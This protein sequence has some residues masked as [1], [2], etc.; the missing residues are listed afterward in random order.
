MALFSCHYLILV[1]CCALFLVQLVIIWIDYSEG[2]TAIGTTFKDDSFKLL[3]CFTFCPLPAYK[4]TTISDLALES[5]LQSY[6][7]STYGRSDIFSPE[8]LQGVT[9]KYER[10]ILEYF[11]SHKFC[12]DITRLIVNIAL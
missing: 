5:S 9:L 2:K 10:Q 4:N 1:I 7:D 8:T 12:R 11:E 3:P 6:M